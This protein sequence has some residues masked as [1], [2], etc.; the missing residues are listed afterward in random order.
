MLEQSTISLPAEIPLRVKAGERTLDFFMVFKDAVNLPQQIRDALKI[1]PGENYLE[2]HLNNLVQAETPYK[3]L[4]MFKTGFRQIAKY[5][6]ENR[7]KPKFL[8][9]ITYKQ[10]ADA[11]SIFKFKTM[12]VTDRISEHELTRIKIG[13]RRT[14]KGQN[15]GLMGPVTA[16]YQPGNEFMRYFNPDIN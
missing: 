9:G 11:A 8:V 5:I 3:M 16:F 4:K 6:S 1:L 7:L 15:I 10:L 14:S 2:M 12:L 13:W